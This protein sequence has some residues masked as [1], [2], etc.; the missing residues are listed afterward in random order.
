MKTLAF[1]LYPE[2]LTPLVPSSTTS[3]CIL[4][5]SFFI[6]FSSRPWAPQGLRSGT[7]LYWPSF[8]SPRSSHVA[9][10]SIH[11]LVWVR[12]RASEMKTIL[13]NLGH[14]VKTCLR[15]LCTKSQWNLIVFFLL[16]FPQILGFL[17]FLIWRCILLKWFILQ[18]SCRPSKKRHALRFQMEMHDLE[19]WGFGSSL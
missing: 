16:P 4:V 18:N 12:H 8:P 14:M 2:L 11:C 3:F 1:L 13:E 15:R 9:W 10:H 17:P 6:A 5:H 19:I 7:H